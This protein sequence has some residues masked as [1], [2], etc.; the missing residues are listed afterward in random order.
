MSND[1]LTSNPI[2]FQDGLS[3]AAN[4]EGQVNAPENVWAS[5]ERTQ[6]WTGFNILGTVEL[7]INNTEVTRYKEV[8]ITTTISHLVEAADSRRDGDENFSDRRNLGSLGAFLGLDPS[9]SQHKELL[10]N[11]FRNKSILDIGS[12]AGAFGDDVMQIE[13]SRVT[14]IDFSL[15]ALRSS[16]DGVRDQIKGDALSLPFRNGGFDRAVSMFS[17]SVHVET[18]LGRLDGVAEMLRVTNP[19]GRAFMVPLFG[20]M[21]LRQ[22]RWYTMQQRRHEPGYWNLNLQVYEEVLRREAALDYALITLLRSLMIAGKIELTPVVVMQERS[23]EVH[24]CISGMFDVNETL[25]KPEATNL[26]NKAA[27]PLL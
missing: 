14:E 24:D 6:R 11:E 1:G 16:A 13:N 26:I 27:A 20:D 7:G 21:I 22:Q 4:P 12:G 8:P 18:L 10:S 25:T 9:D 17:T 5:I 2:F 15:K 3:P 19:G 23:G